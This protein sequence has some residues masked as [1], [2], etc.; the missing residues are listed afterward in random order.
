M[1]DGPTDPALRAELL[2]RMERDQAARSG[3]P[4]TAVP[5][6]LKDV[7]QQNTRWLAALVEDRG[8]PGR[9]EVGEDGALAAWLL[10]Q[11]ADHD[12]AF[13]RRCLVLLA[14]AVDAGE[15]DPAHQAYLTDRTRLREGRPQVYGTQV[16]ADANGFRPQELAEPA[17]VDER[18]ASVGLPPLA[19]YLA[20]FGP[21]QPS[22]FP[23]PDCGSMIEFWPPET[24]AVDL[25]CPACRWHGGLTFSN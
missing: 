16:T 10:A 22:A 6:D 5:E 13:Q 9:S 8:W 17:R 21:P 11:H 7:D 25:I 15:A 19:D 24:G 2:S 18:R 14:G 23:C 12:P 4:G 1:N 20:S 3:E